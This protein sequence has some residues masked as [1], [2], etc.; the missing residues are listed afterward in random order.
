MGGLQFI[1]GLEIEI[2]AIIM[3]IQDILKLIFKDLGIFSNKL[4]DNGG[5]EFTVNLKNVQ[6][7][8]P[9]R[10][11]QYSYLTDKLHSD[12]W[13]GEPINSINV[14]LYLEGDVESNYLDIYYPNNKENLDLITSM[15]PVDDYDH[16][17]NI[18]NFF[19]RLDCVPKKEC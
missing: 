12:I 9:E 17:Q 7:A 10:Y 6:S 14:F 3:R 4:L 11:K 5:M 18:D 19:E 2:I 16:V 1:N 15:K 13:A 8:I